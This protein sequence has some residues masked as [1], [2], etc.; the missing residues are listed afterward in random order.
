MTKYILDTEKIER[1]MVNR[2]LTVRDML[3]KAKIDKMTWHR[4][5]REKRPTAFR[6]VTVLAFVLNVH[7]DDITESIIVQKEKERTNAEQ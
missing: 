3:D 1:L 7:P 5:M 2:K 6:N 4:L